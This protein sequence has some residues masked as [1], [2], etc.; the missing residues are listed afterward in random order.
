V[1]IVVILLSARPTDL[2]RRRPHQRRAEPGA[3][4]RNGGRRTVQGQESGQASGGRRGETLRGSG[5]RRFVR[6]DARPT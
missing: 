5:E 4:C 6:F 2:D 3:A 1:G